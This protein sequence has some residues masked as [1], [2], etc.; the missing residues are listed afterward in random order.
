MENLVYDWYLLL[1]QMY[2]KYHYAL[3]EAGSSSVCGRTARSCWYRLS[4][5]K[6]AH[7]QVEL[8]VFGFG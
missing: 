8:P 4:F 5:M 6:K 3:I 7:H 2:L 1:Y